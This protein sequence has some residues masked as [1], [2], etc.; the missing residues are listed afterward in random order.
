M[1]F[2]VSRGMASVSYDEIPAAEGFREK[3]LSLAKRSGR[4][5]CIEGLPLSA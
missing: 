1:I 2:N 3:F 5:D 4:L